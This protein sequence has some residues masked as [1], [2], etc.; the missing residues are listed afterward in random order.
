M[1]IKIFEA[2]KEEGGACTQSTW[3]FH[4]CNE[5]TVFVSVLSVK[6]T[7]CDWF[8]LVTVI[9]IGADSE[10]AI[11]DAKDLNM[12]LFAVSVVSFF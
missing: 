4:A 8:L 9:G 7:G 2:L 1:T 3:G 11:A 10:Q 6:Y 5:A 12:L